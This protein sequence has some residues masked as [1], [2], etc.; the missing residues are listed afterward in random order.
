MWHLTAISSH[1]KPLCKVIQSLIQLYNVLCT[2][3]V[4]TIPYGIVGIL[5]LFIL[6]SMVDGSDRFCSLM[7]MKMHV[8]DLYSGTAVANA[9]CCCLFKVFLYFCINCESAPDYRKK[10]LLAVKHRGNLIEAT[11]KMHPSLL[12]VFI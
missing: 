5:Y 11:C 12:V 2:L 3:Y 7:E 8:I 9:C 10:H 6:C 1:S 4:F